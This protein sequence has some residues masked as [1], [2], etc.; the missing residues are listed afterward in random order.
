MSPK[1]GESNFLRQD[2]VYR[3]LRLILARAASFPQQVFP[4][5]SNKL[6]V[7]GI[8]QPCLAAAKKHNAC[9][10]QDDQAGEQRQHA[11]ADQLTVGD[12]DAG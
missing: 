3:V 6:A 12:E 7:P 4:L 1:A 11:E 8:S 10:A 2:D 5:L 9:G